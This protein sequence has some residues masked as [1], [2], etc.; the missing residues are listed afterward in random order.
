MGG[1]FGAISSILRHLC[2]VIPLIRALP[3]HASG[4]KTVSP[5]IPPRKTGIHC[6]S[7]P[8]SRPGKEPISGMR[9]TK[10]PG[11]PDLLSRLTSLPLQEY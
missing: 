5:P 4:L 8:F 3:H 9:D 2:G 11:A 10:V 1:Q 6:R 7:W